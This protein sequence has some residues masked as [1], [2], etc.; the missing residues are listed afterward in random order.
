MCKDV[1]LA[2]IKKDTTSVHMSTS[3]PDFAAFFSS[4][5]NTTRTSL[6]GHTIGAGYALPEKDLKADPQLMTLSC[7]YSAT[8][9]AR[10]QRKSNELDRKRKGCVELYCRT[11]EGKYAGTKMPMLPPTILRKKVVHDDKMTWPNKDGDTGPV[12]DEMHIYKA[13]NHC[14]RCR[15]DQPPAICWPRT[16]RGTS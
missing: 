14:R 2:C 4:T 7:S 10:A 15:F 8:F 5:S 1:C 9:S 13:Q 12:A 6:D 3:N 16:C 11:C